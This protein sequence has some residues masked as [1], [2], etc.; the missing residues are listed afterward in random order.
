MNNPYELD[1]SKANLKRKIIVDNS[2][3]KKQAATR[4][5]R[6]EENKESMTNL[7]YIV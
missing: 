6:R 4:K 5:R 7:P 1:F 2:P 3:V